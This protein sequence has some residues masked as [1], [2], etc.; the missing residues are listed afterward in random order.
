MVTQLAM[1]YDKSSHQ[2][3]LDTVKKIVVSSTFIQIAPL[4]LAGPTQLGVTSTHVEIFF[5]EKG[6]AM[7][8]YHKLR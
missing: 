7:W 4:Y 3:E 5:L 1:A 6:L 2:L 8:I